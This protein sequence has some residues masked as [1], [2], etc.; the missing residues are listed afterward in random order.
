MASTHSI[1]HTCAT[2]ESEATN[3]MEENHK[4]HTSATESVQQASSSSM[5]L[6]SEY[7]SEED[8]SSEDLSTIETEKIAV[9]RRIK[10]LQTEKELQE[11]QQQCDTL[12]QELNETIPATQ[13][14]LEAHPNHSR[15]ATSMNN[16]HNNIISILRPSE[17]TLQAL[18]IL[19]KSAVT[20]VS[21]RHSW[22]PL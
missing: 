19:M 3:I 4:T 6:N 14:T 1:H 16:N 12:L 13:N 20:T 9:T 11:L 18:N 17:A 10:K 15:D 7:S 5:K 21:G 22:V 2:T 8:T